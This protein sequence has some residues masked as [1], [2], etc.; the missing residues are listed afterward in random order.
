MQTLQEI[1]VTNGANSQ[2]IT[3]VTDEKLTVGDLRKRL[4][5]VLNIAPTAIALIG[6]EE[7]DDERVLEP[8]DHLQFIKRS[9]SKG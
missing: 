7:V 5:D 2:P 9:G 6:D 3:P 8:G 1:T 4:G